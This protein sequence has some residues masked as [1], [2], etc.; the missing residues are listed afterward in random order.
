MCCDIRADEN[1]CGESG[2]LFE[3]RQNIEHYV[4]QAPITT[5]SRAI[6]DI[7]AVQRESLG[8][9]YVHD[10]DIAS[11]IQAKPLPPGVTTD[12]KIKPFTDYTKDDDPAA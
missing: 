4:E 9:K 2:K 6:A 7:E 1:K 5:Y 12:P 8:K 11:H 10:E 3:Q